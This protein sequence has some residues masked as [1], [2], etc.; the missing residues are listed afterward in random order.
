MGFIRGIRLDDHPVRASKLQLTR[1]ARGSAGVPDSLGHKQGVTSGG[2]CGLL[3]SHSIPV[4]NH[5]FLTSIFPQLPYFS[6]L[7]PLLP[8]LR[9]FRARRCP[10]R[11][12]CALAAR[13]PG[14]GSA[15]DLR[16]P[17]TTGKATSRIPRM[18]RSH[19][20]VKSLE[21]GWDLVLR[22]AR[23]RVIIELSPG[24][25]KSSNTAP[26]ASYVRR[27]APAK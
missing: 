7:F 25:R 12:L 14:R 4:G 2:Q 1:G 17:T 16:K 11:S 6:I 15:G 24:N 13:W 20:H 26:G 22:A 18:A 19:S 3:P 21:N 10:F 8:G 23:C 27:T 5:S 9:L